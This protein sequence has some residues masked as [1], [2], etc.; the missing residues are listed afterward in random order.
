[1]SLRDKQ[2]AILTADDGIE[3]VE[4]TAPRRALETEGARVV[5]VTPGGG[6]ARTFDQTEPSEYIEPTR[7]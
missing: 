6:R 3:R 5:R 2:I 1:M 4:L 7:P